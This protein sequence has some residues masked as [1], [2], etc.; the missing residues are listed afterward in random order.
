[1]GNGDNV[2]GIQSSCPS[3]GLNGPNASLGKCRSDGELTCGDSSSFSYRCTAHRAAP[4]CY[5][6]SIISDYITEQSSSSITFVTVRAVAS[7]SAFSSMEQFVAGWGKLQVVISPT[8]LNGAEP[9]PQSAYPPTASFVAAPSSAPTPSLSLPKITSPASSSSSSFGY[10]TTAE[11]IIAAA[12]IPD[13]IDGAPWQHMGVHVHIL[14]SATRSSSTSSTIADV[15]I[16]VVRWSPASPSPSR[17][18]QDAADGVRGVRVTATAIVVESHDTVYFTGILLTF[19]EGVV[20]F[21]FCY[22]LLFAVMFIF[23]GV[24]QIRGGELAL[25][26]AEANQREEHHSTVQIDAAGVSGAGVKAAIKQNEDVANNDAVP[27]AAAEAVMQRTNSREAIEAARSSPATMV[28][29]HKPLSVS[30]VAAESDLKPAAQSKSAVAPAAPEPQSS[31][32]APA[33]SLAPVAA[34]TKAAMLDSLDVIVAS[35][36][37]AA[38]LSAKGQSATS[39]AM[40]NSSGSTPMSNKASNVFKAERARTAQSFSSVDTNAAAAPPPSSQQTTAAA[41]SKMAPASKEAVNAAIDMF[42]A[43]API[44]PPAPAPLPAKTDPASLHRASAAKTQ[45]ASVAAS[46]ASNVASPVPKLDL[47][48]AVQEQVC[49]VGRC[50]Q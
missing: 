14:V 45:E 9:F 37:P 7:V 1:M 3:C 50:V 27:R 31:A 40:P 49:G 5:S 8:F 20:L 28:I 18:V 38:L 24:R 6:P 36:T 2:F 35:A 11:A 48:K 21:C 22:L 25:E 4:S 47:T 39:A 44:P 16:K 33:P 43:S 34:S 12:G 42:K 26:D 10:V 23:Y 19:A 46:R 30:I 32:P 13:T 41:K 15:V 17:P 29:Q